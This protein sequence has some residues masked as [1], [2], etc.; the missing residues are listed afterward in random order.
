MVKRLILSSLAILALLL[1]QSSITFS[2]IFEIS[3]VKPNILLVFVLLLSLKAGLFPSFFIGFS[4]GFLTDLISTGYFGFY[5]LPFYLT[6]TSIGYFKSKIQFNKIT[7]TFITFFFALLLYNFILFLLITLFY[8]LISALYYTKNIILLE[9]VL[10]TLLFPI[11][12]YCIMAV[13]FIIL[14]IEKRPVIG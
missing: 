10:N 4:C 11:V 5:L 14:K 12:Y 3:H 2:K 13:N 6:C 8:D 7:I 9:L 1:L